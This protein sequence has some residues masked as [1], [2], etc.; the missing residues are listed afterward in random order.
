MTSLEKSGHNKVREVVY[1]FNVQG[2]GAN[3]RGF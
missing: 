1:Q 2:G 3:G